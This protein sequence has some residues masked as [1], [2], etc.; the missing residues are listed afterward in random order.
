MRK[1][2]LGLASL[3]VGG[4]AVQAQPFPATAPGEPI[5]FRPAQAVAPYQ[6]APSYGDP[7][8]GY[9]G[10]RFPGYGDP[11]APTS[12]Q[13]PIPIAP[14]GAFPYNPAL[15]APARPVGFPGAGASSAAP[16]E[17]PG[18]APMAA[19]APSSIALTDLV[20]RWERRQGGFD[21]HRPREETLWVKTD[22]ILSWI[23]QG[24][25]HA[26]LV[27]TGPSVP[28]GGTL[29]NPG[30]AVIFGGHNL[31]FGLLGG[32]RAEAGIWFDPENRYS[33]DISGFVLSPTNI[34]FSA[35]SDA[36]RN[37]LIAR[38]VINATT[39]AEGQ[40]LTSFPGFVAGVT[41]VQN[42]ADLWG[43]EL[44]CRTHG[45]WR[46]RVHAEGLVGFRTIN[47]RE[48]IRIQDS[49]TDLNDG[50]VTF[51]GAPLNAG[52]RLFDQDLF[53]TSNQFY[54]FQFG[55]ALTCER[56]WFTLGLISKLGLGV[57]DQQSIISGFTSVESQTLG[58]ATAPGGV[59]AQL[60]N[61][62]DRHSYVFGI[63]PEFGANL[64]V[65][66]HKN[67]RFTMG[68]TFLLWNSVLRPGDLI[69]RS[70]NPGLPPGSQFFGQAGPPVPHYVSRE[71]TFVV[72]TFNF[73]L[74]FHY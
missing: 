48:T 63:V 53:Q 5:G 46:E 13:A 39:G 17:M 54:G 27:T 74:E 8:Y 31:D 37:P 36:A 50:F 67:V 71:T 35:G 4:G 22:F 49:L 68:Y 32:I 47:L 28:T 45:Y 55:G 23:T 30:T 62:G 41:T 12:Q 44:N 56:D 52:D 15:G 61:I 38:P 6:G 16:S 24:P 69:D 40:Y 18:P 59:L 72:Q 25:L 7:A 34:N 26:P 65:N 3:L 64:G 73:G 57:T 20:P 43:V 1:S 11:T 10:S 42:R 58:N 2:W 33:L 60:T 14:P 51:N 21:F 70:V 66:L 29:G 19:Q 9:A